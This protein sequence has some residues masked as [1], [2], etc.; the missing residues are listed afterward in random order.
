[1]PRWA[2][3]AGASASS[4]ASL[5]EFASLPVCPSSEC[6]R[7]SDRPARL[8]RWRLGCLQHEAWLPPRRLP[9]SATADL[10][11]FGDC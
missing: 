8:Q 4:V 1:M 2:L 5:L 3:R 7:G 11:L 6:T 10:W 9:A